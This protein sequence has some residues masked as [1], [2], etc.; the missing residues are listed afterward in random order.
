MARWNAVQRRAVSRAGKA[1]VCADLQ[2]TK[3]CGALGSGC[4]S[5]L[6]TFQRVAFVCRGLVDSYMAIE[7]RP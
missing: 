1:Y 5:A 3:S 2:G 7:N 4:G 6:H